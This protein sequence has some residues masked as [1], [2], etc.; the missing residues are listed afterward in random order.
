MNTLQAAQGRWD[1]ILKHYGL[2]ISGNKHYESCPLCNKKKKFR[3]H[4]RDGNAFWICVC[5]N[6]SCID[7]LKD[8]TGLVADTGITQTLHDSA[9]L[10]GVDIYP[11]IGIPKCMISGAN[12]Y[13]DQIYTRLALKVRL[14]ISGFNF[15]AQTT[16]KIPQTEEGMDG[17]KGSYRAVLAQFVVAGVYA[18]GTWNSSETFGDPA[19]HIR[20][21]KERGYFIYSA[22]VAL[23][24]QAE[25]EARIAPAIQIAA[26]E[27]GAIHS[28][29]LT[30][31]IEA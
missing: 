4:E 15:L 22:P 23:Q 25:R 1:E 27:S 8:I 6:G 30:I 3:I 26:K 7:L 20:N 13:S 2:W 10:G 29:D 24:A 17:L 12:L 31:L 11:D 5:G 14:Q 18:P 19:D 28:S 21:I 16:T 9:K